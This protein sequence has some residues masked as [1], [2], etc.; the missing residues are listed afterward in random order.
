LVVRHYYSLKPPNPRSEFE[1]AKR[2]LPKNAV[3][4]ISTSSIEE[5]QK[6]IADGA[7]YLGIG[8]MFATPT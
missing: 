1:E 5:A 8:T 3:I 7:D 6:A 2:L 4:G